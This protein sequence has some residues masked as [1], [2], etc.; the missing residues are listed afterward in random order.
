LAKPKVTV[1]L[2]LLDTVD[3]KEG[4]GQCSDLSP[5]FVVVV[6]LIPR[7]NMLRIEDDIF[8]RFEAQR[9]DKEE[10]DTQW[11]RISTTNKKVGG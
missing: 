11:G 8:D 3:L 9:T 4:D 2:G 5:A 6:V 1:G 7:T 10:E